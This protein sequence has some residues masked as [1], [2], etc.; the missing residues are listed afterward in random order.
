MKS[1][2]LHSK[3]LRPK[4]CQKESFFFLEMNCSEYCRK[5]HWLPEEKQG[6]MSQFHTV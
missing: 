2:S 1:F 6:F 4:L 3:A 5:A